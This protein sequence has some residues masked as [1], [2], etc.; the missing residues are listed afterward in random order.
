[1]NFANLINSYSDIGHYI[2]TKI[3][4][5]LDSLQGSPMSVIIVVIESSIL[6]WVSS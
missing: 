6:L 2:V 3:P 5:W 4:L 1:M